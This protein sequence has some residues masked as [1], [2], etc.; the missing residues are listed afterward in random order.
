M[1]TR[2]AIAAASVAML[3]SAAPAAL[4]D[5]PLAPL[6]FG[7][8][9]LPILAKNCFLCHGPDDSDR[10]ADL[11]LDNFAAATAGRD[12][13]PPAIVPGK[14]DESELVARIESADAEQRM[15]PADSKQQLTPEQKRTLRRWVAEGAAY[16]PHWAYQPLARPAVPTVTNNVWPAGDIDRFVLHKLEERGLAPA[17]Q[18]A[19]ETLLR[20]LSFD[21]VGLPP[22]PEEV[23]TIR[24]DPSPTAWPAAID[25]LL[26]SP[27]YGEHWAR[28]WMDVVRY[29]DST[30]YETDQLLG[31][32]WQYRDWI[33][34]SF[35]SNKPLDRF[36]QE[37][38]AGDQL[39]PDSDEARHGSLFLSVGRH[40]TEGGLNREPERYQE[41]LTDVVDTVGS[42]LTG[43]TLGCAR[44]HDHKFDRFAQREYYSLQAIF[45]DSKIGENPPGNASDQSRPLNLI[46][47]TQPTPLPV[48]L[49]FRGEFSAP[50]ETVPPALPVS[51]GGQPPSAATDD[52]PLRRA[53]LAGWLTGAGKS[54][55][56]RVLVN[57]VWQWHF[58]QGLVR[59]PND[60]GV[61]GERPNHP[62]LLEFLAC[63]LVDHDWNLQHLQ[64]L[65]LNSATYR[66]SS[67]DDPQTAVLDPECRW[68]SRFPRRRL[69]AEELRDA[70]LECAGEL[71]RK[72][73]GVFV[74][75]PTQDWELAS[76][77]NQN[78][79]VTADMREH[80]RR[81]VYLIVR[82]S[83]RPAM[84]DAFNVP[85]TISSCPV[86]DATVVPTQAL[87]LLNSETSL[88]RARGLSGRLWNESQGDAT[89]AARR[90][91]LIVFGRTARAEEI[92][93]AEEFLAAREAN[94]K[95]H[96]PGD[97]AQP[98]GVAGATPDKSRGAAW[99]EWCLALL[100]ANEFIYVD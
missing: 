92:R 51:L 3:C 9:V 17:V 82:R 84:L 80:R 24:S 37:Q 27:H 70:L 73:F 63:E 20:R 22:A 90:A 77:R 85:D 86:R 75:P 18:A 46:P 44:C 99:V 94:W 15:P 8:D 59:T 67:L 6:D 56:A 53:D 23:E 93:Q 26:A 5:P 79:I 11:R 96:P 4:A 30:G 38:I 62:E 42:A 66:M 16:R 29:G 95:A 7:R 34:R 98:R 50:R 57:R 49:L 78:W 83:V 47:I 54:I 89:A 69:Q 19:P 61:Q 12:T 87:L 100:N 43:S 72:Q 41:W 39:W 40:R 88:E 71:N 81:T 76:L 14:P 74:V 1:Y 60:F 48:Q 64:R 28:H 35:N 36:L 32:A 58:G 21:L 68:L 45:A 55:V 97:A 33:I 65:I 31:N 91:W 52:K 2:W 13:R 10:Q 25:R